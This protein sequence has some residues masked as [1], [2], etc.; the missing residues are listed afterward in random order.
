[1]L[2]LA[3]IVVY[4]LV[5]VGGT[6]YETIAEANEDV[7]TFAETD[8]PEMADRPPSLESWYLW[9]GTDWIGKSVLLKTILGAKVSMTVALIA[10]VIAVP[11]GMVLG[12]VAGFYGGKRDAVIVWGFSTLASIPGIVLLISLKFAFN[13]VEFQIG[14]WDFSLAGLFGLCLALG[15][16]SWIGTCRLV[17]AETMKLRELDYVMAARATGMSGF[18]ILLRHIMP[19][20]LHLGIINF[21]LGFV[22]AIKGEVIL[23]YLGLG[24]KDDTSWGHMINTGRE[25]LHAG[26]WW[27]MTSAVVAMFILILALSVFGDRLRDAFDPRLRTS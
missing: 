21:S 24:I 6:V 8:R 10:N 23:S 12:A 18:P 19:N 22:G 20:I 1:M 13:R 16:I 9:L 27:E 5:A 11:L 14:G 4:A 25:G 3:V 15:A 17:R 2:C 7:P 26:Q